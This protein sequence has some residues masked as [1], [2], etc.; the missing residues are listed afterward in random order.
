MGSGRRI[1]IWDDCWLLSPIPQR[2]LFTQVSH[3]RLVSDLMLLEEM[4]WNVGLV[5]FVFSADEAML[6]KSVPLSTFPKMI[7]EFGEVNT[8][9]S[10]VFVVAIDYY[11]GLLVYS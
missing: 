2:I 5:D 6:I 10:I 11:F 1:S 4:A 3:L 8:Q 7:V 9:V